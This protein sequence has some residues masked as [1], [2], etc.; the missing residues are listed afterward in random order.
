[1]I[2]YYNAVAVITFNQL[3]YNTTEDNGLTQR[4]SLIQPQLLLSIPSSFGFA[5]RV[6]TESFNATAGGSAGGYHLQHPL[7]TVC[8]ICR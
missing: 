4:P 2:F 8:I 5:I 3:V 7:S 1:M 6:N